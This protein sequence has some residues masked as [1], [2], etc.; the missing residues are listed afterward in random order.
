LRKIRNKLDLDQGSHK[1]SGLPQI[2]S[3]LNSLHTKR[4]Q[5]QQQ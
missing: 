4:A 2:R 5:E 3:A 1:T